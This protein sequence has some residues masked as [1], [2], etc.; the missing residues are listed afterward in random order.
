VTPA[1]WSYYLKC[2][3]CEAPRQTPCLAMSGGHD[4]RRPLPRPHPDRPRAKWAPKKP[5]RPGRRGDPALR[6]DRLTIWRRL[7]R[8]GVPVVLIAERLEM[9]R[10]ALLRLV[11][12]ARADGH[13]DAVYHQSALINGVVKTRHPAPRT[14]V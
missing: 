13:P 1:R 14:R 3:Y 6:A 11:D 5:T 9:T 4:H 12:R 10:A 2:P 7:A 8:E